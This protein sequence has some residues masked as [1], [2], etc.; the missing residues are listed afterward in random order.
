M[1][2][3]PALVFVPGGW[4]TAQTWEKVVSIMERKGHKC[5]SITLATTT[6]DPSATVKDD[7]DVIRGAITSETS[8]G[9]D[10]VVVV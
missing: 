8:Q 4:H 3:K 9:R 7:V 10:V 6:G 2:Q 5:L 1:S